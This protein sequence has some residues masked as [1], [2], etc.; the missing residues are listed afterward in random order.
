MNIGFVCC[1]CER[2][3]ELV[4]IGLPDNHIFMDVR[5]LHLG[6]LCVWQ[7]MCVQCDE[8]TY[9]IYRVCMLHVRNIDG[10]SEHRV[11]V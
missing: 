6:P 2:Y 11:C 7:V 8:T 3:I 9:L 1:R 4:N 10:F 5:N